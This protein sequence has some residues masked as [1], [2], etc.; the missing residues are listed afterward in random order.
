MISFTFTLNVASFPAK[1]SEKYSSGNLTFISFSSPVFIPIICSSNPGIK[2]P[3]PISSSWFS[4]FPPSKAFPSTYPSKSI[5]VISFSFTGLSSTVIVLA[6]CSC[7]CAIS[8]STSSSVTGY[9]TFFNSTPLYL[10]NFTSGFV[11]TIAVN[12][13]SSPFFIFTIFISGLLTTSNLL[14]SISFS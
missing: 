6:L 11:W 4:A 2:A 1:S 12:T 14:S 3:L 5:T 7:I 10:P 13:R 9:S 8:C